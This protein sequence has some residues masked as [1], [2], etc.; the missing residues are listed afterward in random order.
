MDMDLEKDDFNINIPTVHIETDSFTADVIE[1]YEMPSGRVMPLMSL[2]GPEQMEE[3]LA[4]FKLAIVDPAKVAELDTLSF[5]EMSGVLTKWYMGSI[6]RM[7]RRAVQLELELESVGADLDD[8]LVDLKSILEEDAN[9]ESKT[10]GLKTNFNI[11]EKDDGSI[12]IIRLDG[13]A[14]NDPG[15]NISPFEL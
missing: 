3:M 14:S 15:D 13:P 7:R 4:V 2:T 9:K 1:M 12:E 5:G 8:L 10:S 11:R 6:V